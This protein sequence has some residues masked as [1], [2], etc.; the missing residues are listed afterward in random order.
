[1]SVARKPSDTFSLAGAFGGMVAAACCAGLPAAAAL[2]GGLG[3]VALL[4]GSAAVLIAGVLGAALVGLLRAR[5]RRCAA[6]R[7]RHRP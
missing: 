4:V 5:R 2:L 7:G 3:T 6:I 1:L